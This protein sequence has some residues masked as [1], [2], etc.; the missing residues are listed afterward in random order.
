MCRAKNQF[1]KLEERQIFQNTLFR[2]LEL[3]KRGKERRK[4]VW[5]KFGLNPGR[6]ESSSPR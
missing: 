2:V 4:L 1:L 5:E 6:S 3:K